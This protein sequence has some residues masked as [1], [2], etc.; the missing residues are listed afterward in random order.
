MAYRR[1]WPVIQETRA[2][3]GG[4]RFQEGMVSIK[5]S[6]YSILFTYIFILLILL[7]ETAS[8]ELS[9]LQREAGGETAPVREMRDGGGGAVF[10]AEP[11]EPAEGGSGFRDRI[12]EGEREFEGDGW[13]FEGELSDGAE[14]AG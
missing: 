5:C 13:D 9:E 3:V 12:R 8:D 2:R 1:S 11:G 6:V 14:P 10:A 4:N 7:R